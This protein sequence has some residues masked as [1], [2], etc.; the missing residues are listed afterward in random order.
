MK[1]PETEIKGPEIDI[2]LFACR[3]LSIFG[4]ITMEIERPSKDR[5]YMRRHTEDRTRSSVYTHGRGI[6]ASQG[7]GNYAI[8]R[9][10]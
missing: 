4:V 9:R 6:S 10:G 5:S 3:A 7:Q 2:I 8:H 1:G